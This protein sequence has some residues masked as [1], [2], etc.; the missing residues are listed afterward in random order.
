MLADY[1]TVTGSNKFALKF[2]QVRW[3][4]NHDVAKRALEVF[5]DFKKYMKEKLKSLPKTTT[6]NNMEAVSDP[7]TVPKLAFFAS[8]A[9]EIEP[10]LKKY[11]TAQPMAVCLSVRRCCWNSSCNSGPVFE[12]A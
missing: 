7:L 8:V 5:D 9:E 2:C 1:I 4:E 6:C 11:E 3:V 10:F 12:E